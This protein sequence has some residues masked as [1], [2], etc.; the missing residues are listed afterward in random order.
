[1]PLS[2]AQYGRWRF[3]LLGAGLA[4]ATSMPVS[5]DDY[6][7]ALTEEVEEGGAFVD[8]TSV[9]QVSSED[10]QEALKEKMPTTARL[11]TGLDPG[12]QEEVLEVYR[13]T[14]SISKVSLEVL[15]RSR[16]RSR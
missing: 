13:E 6:L 12:D 4:I 1:M 11:Y 15:K 10:L 9:Q 14:L 7:D 3:I 8:K 16:G 5:G 2:T